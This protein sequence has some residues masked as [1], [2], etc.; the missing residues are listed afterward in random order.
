MSGCASDRAWREIPHSRGS[1]PIVRFL[2]AETAETAIG[3]R[4]RP[5]IPFSPAQERA[6]ARAPFS[7]DSPRLPQEKKTAPEDDVVQTDDRISSLAVGAPPSSRRPAAHAAEC[8]GVI[9]AVFHQKTIGDRARPL[10]RAGSKS[11]S[12]S[13][14]RSPQYA[15]T[16]NWR[17][18][19]PT[20][21]SRRHRGSESIFPG[22]HERPRPQ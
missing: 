17:Q 3:R 8:A 13:Y 4:P 18:S 9:P 21:G 2:P 10:R 5:L 1:C 15:R 16:G 19:V 20:E 7:I 12:N 22:H 6:A 11:V 14:G